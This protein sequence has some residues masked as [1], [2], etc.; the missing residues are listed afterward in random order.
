MSRP[1]YGL[2][3]GLT[4]LLSLACGGLDDSPGS[5]GGSTVGA[6]GDELT[7]DGDEATVT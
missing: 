6:V 5:A 3:G 7:V 2:L 1:T 4:V